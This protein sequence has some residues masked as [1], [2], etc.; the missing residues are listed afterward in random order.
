M[1]FGHISKINLNE[2]PKAIQVALEYLKNTDFDKLE[3]GRYTLKGDLIYVQVLDLET[4]PKAE[5]L[6]EIHRTFLDV[7]YL[8]AG[9][10]RIGV[11]PDLGTNEIAIPYNAERDILFYKNVQGESE[12]IMRP[13]SFAVFFPEDIHR[14]ACID[15]ESS[16]IRKV[17]V[18]IAIS[19]IRGDL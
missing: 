16:N 13:G 17:V 14:P 9:K 7:Q 10:E 11:A 1:F 8:H 6:P 18:K 4:K 2:Y 5:N 19:E 15:G 3:T 12:L